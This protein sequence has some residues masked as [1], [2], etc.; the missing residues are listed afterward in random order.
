MDPVVIE[1]GKDRAQIHLLDIGGWIEGSI[2]LVIWISAPAS[3]VAAP[4]RPCENP[5]P[6]RNSVLPL[7]VVTVSVRPDQDATTRDN[8]VLPLPDILISVIPNVT[9]VPFLQIPPPHPLVEI[10]VRVALPP[11]SVLPVGGPG[12]A[13]GVSIGSG[14]RAVAV[15]PPGLEL[16]LERRAGRPRELPLSGC[17]PPAPLSLVHAAVLPEVLSGTV[18]DASDEAAGV[19]IAV[20]EQ[21]LDTVRAAGPGG[22]CRCDTA[23]GGVGAGASYG[24]DDRRRR[25]WDHGEMV[26]LVERLLLLRCSRGGDFIALELPHSRISRGGIVKLAAAAFQGRATE[27]LCSLP[28]SFPRKMLNLPRFSSIAVFRVS[29]F[30]K[31]RIQTN[32]PNKEKVKK[33]TK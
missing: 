9:A 29:D 27:N 8:A 26:V 28:P 13:V 3:D 33:T 16:A 23:G 10:S 4:V 15:H 11:E 32:L 6:S 7:P 17:L 20:G 31:Q 5:T 30:P 18:R 21:P 2:Q 25:G 24:D 1:W 14:E 19:E 12:A 22:G